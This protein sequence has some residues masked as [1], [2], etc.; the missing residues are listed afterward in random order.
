MHGFIPQVVEAL[1]GMPPQAI[2]LVIS[3]LPGLESRGG[4]IAGINFLHRPA[5]EVYLWAC[6]SNIAA[7]APVLAFIEPIEALLRR[8]RAARFLLRWF[9]RAA[10]RHKRQIERWGYWGLLLLVS[11]PLPGTAAWTGVALVALLGMRRA[12]ALAAISAGVFVC[13]VILAAAASGANAVL[14]TWFAS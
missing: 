12:P 1:R 13:G 2:V 8:N 7:I 3:V 5:L 11:T 9:F 6:L 14:K 4:I 10:E